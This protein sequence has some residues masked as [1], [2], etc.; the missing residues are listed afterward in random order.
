M[1]AR[2]G[3]WA[4]LQRQLEGGRT[5]L[6][7]LALEGSPGMGK[8]TLWRAAVTDARGR[9]FRVI[10]TAPAEPDRALAFAGLGDLFDELPEGALGSLPE[11]QRR[12]MAAALFVDLVAGSGIQFE[13][14]GAHELKGVPGKWGLHAV[15]RASSRV[16]VSSDGA[17]A[18][19][20]GPKSGAQAAGRPSG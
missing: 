3:E 9:G 13:P 10:A 17:V 15:V 19:R 14:R 2:E 12:A 6:S 20:S 1:F 11:P 18:D 5:Q 4:E 7:G 8:T 16:S